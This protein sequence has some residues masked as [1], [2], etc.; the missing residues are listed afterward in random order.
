MDFLQDPYTVYIDYCAIKTHF[1]T[2]QYNFFKS[3]G[4]TRVNRNSFENRKDKPFFYHLASKLNRSDNVPFFV[5][6][7]IEGNCYVGDLVLEK[8]IAEKRYSV[9][10]HRLESLTDN[11]LLDLRNIAIQG[12]TWNTIFTYK[13]GTHPP[14]F[15]LVHQKKITPETYIFLDYISDFIKITYTKLDDFYKALN[16]KFLKYEDCINVNRKKLLEITPKNLN[17]LL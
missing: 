13:A 1:T 11:Y 12:Y 17:S 3:N 10:A 9:W 16:L 5:A 4:K 6:Q 7:F 14:L 15:L 8:A 2:L